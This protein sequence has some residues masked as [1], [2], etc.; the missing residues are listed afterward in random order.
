MVLIFCFLHSF[1]IE[2]SDYGV[3]IYQ[4]KGG[5]QLPLNNT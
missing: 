5:K 3:D 1:N 2:G 4:V